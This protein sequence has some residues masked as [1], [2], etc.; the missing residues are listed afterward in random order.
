[1]CC[2]NAKPLNLNPAVWFAVTLCILLI[3]FVAG[4]FEKQKLDAEDDLYCK[5]VEEKR[6]PDFNH[7]YDKLC[8][9]N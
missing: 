2:Q 5:R 6:W 9:P 3:F 1:M 7:N 8:K 4:I